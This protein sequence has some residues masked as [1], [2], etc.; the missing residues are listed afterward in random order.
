M[1]T[2][3]VNDYLS[4]TLFLGMS[5]GGSVFDQPKATDAARKEISES[6]TGMS[7]YIPAIKSAWNERCP[8]QSLKFKMDK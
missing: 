6:R 3:D 7:R 8:F 4:I 1:V 5:N 2:Q